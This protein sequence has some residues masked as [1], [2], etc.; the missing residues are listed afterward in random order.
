MN[1]PTSALADRHCPMVPGALG[2]LVSTASSYSLPWRSRWLMICSE[3]W[4]LSEGAAQRFLL[5]CLVRL[6]PECPRLI[7]GSGP[8]PHRTHPNTVSRSRGHNPQAAPFKGNPSGLALDSLPLPSTHPV[9]RAHTAAF[10]TRPRG[11]HRGRLG[12]DS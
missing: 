7:Q 3:G 6:H 8:A 9:P 5:N 2:P 1:G 11:P 12:Q 4:G 10:G